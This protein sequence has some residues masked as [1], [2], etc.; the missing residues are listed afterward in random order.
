MKTLMRT[1]AVALLAFFLIAISPSH[2]SEDTI[3]PS[4]QNVTIYNQ[5]PADLRLF[6]TTIVDS[7]SFFFT[8]MF[9]DC[10]GGSFD[11]QAFGLY[12]GSDDS[13]VL[14]EP[15]LT[16]DRVIDSCQVQAFIFDISTNDLYRQIAKSG[17]AVILIYGSTRI[18]EFELTPFGEQQILDLIGEIER[19]D[20]I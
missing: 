7:T 14:I 19:S 13:Q 3:R 6:K 8:G 5:Y 10:E 9:A 15:S 17:N 11:V 4:T 2:T 18:L 1:F 20:S 12:S 16:K